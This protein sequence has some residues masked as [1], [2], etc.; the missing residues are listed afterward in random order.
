MPRN[1]YTSMYLLVNEGRRQGHPFHF[2]RRKRIIF[3]CGCRLFSLSSRSTNQS[4]VK[5]QPN[6]SG[7]RN[8][9]ENHSAS[10]SCIFRKVPFSCKNYLEVEIKTNLENWSLALL[11]SQSSLL[12]TG[13]SLVSGVLDLRHQLFVL[14]LDALAEEVVEVVLDGQDLL[15]LGPRLLRDV[16][17]T[18][19]LVLA[20]L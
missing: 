15:Q 19:R 7:C 11:L 9:P 14:P 13:K 4:N 10:C 18:R 3:F 2:G 16:R 8:H 12:I 6:A 20:Q 1:A 5:C 17:H